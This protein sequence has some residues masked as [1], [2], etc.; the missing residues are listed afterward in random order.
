ME[1]QKTMVER[2]DFEI[3]PEI[4]KESLMKL[5]NQVDAL[6]SESEKYS[7][8]DIGNVFEEMRPKINS[9]VD[10]TFEEFP[11][12]RTTMDIPE[13]VSQASPKKSFLE[14]KMSFLGKRT[15]TTAN[16]PSSSLDGRR[17]KRKADKLYEA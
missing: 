11:F 10:S 12:S 9:I 16:F 2:F 7:V 1:K 5:K 6:D 8:I 15:F 17:Q 3:N 4:L 14:E 13:K